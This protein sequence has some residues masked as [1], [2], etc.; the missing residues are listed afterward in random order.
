[1]LDD[2]QGRTKTVLTRVDQAAR[3]AARSSDT[4]TLADQSLRGNQPLML[5]LEYLLDL[6]NQRFSLSEICDLLDVGGFV[7]LSF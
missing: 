7:F 3:E 6:P 5:A 4:Y 2:V 1:M